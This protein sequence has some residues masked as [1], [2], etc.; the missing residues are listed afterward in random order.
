MFTR[1]FLRIPED[2]SPGAGAP[3]ADAPSAD[4][5][6]QPVQLTQR[7]LDELIGKRLGEARER[8][9]IEGYQRAELEFAQRAQQAEIDEALALLREKRA[10]EQQKTAGVQAWRN[11]QAFRA[12]AAKPE[13]DPSRLAR[14]STPP[15]APAPQKSALETWAELQLAREMN[16]AK[17]AE[18]AAKPAPTASEQ[19]GRALAKA[20]E[21]KG[22]KLTPIE[23]R[24]VLNEE[25]AKLKPAVGVNDP[26]AVLGALIGKRGR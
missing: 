16:A 19:I 2:A 26:T 5:A 20:A 7:Q 10:A 17:Q 25:F 24:D 18:Q 1:P 13:Y 4:G 9:S 23:K 21:R 6:D 22:S 15:P 12:Y 8:Y 14:P 3:S 11:Q